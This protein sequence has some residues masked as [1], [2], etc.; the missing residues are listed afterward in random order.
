MA[1]L[2]EQGDWAGAE[3]QCDQLERYCAREPLPWSGFVIARGRA[4]ATVGRGE[5]SD[6][7]LAAAFFSYPRRAVSPFPPTPNYFMAITIESG[8]TSGSTLVLMKPAS[9][10]QP[11]Q[12]APV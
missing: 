8:P 6:A 1:A 2:L 4:F 11:V 10:I 12:S 7:L 5:E 9:R 3:R